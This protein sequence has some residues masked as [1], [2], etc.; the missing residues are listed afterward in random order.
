MSESSSATQHNAMLFYF[1]RVTT[2]QSD[3]NNPSIRR[4]V[5]IYEMWRD[6][7]DPAKLW[8]GSIIL[9]DHTVLRTI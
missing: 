5:A 4:G 6:M 3:T 8:L 2:S 7:V 9:R 1:P